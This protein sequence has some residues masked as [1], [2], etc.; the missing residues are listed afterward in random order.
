MFRTYAERI[1]CAMEKKGIS[2]CE[3]VK[4]TGLN[5]GAISSYLNNKYKPKQD[6]IYLLA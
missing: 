3:L 4:G 1:K 5:K 2:Q 6:A